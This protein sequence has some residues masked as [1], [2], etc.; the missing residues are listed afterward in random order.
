MDLIIGLAAA[1]LLFLPVLI[2]LI[3]RN[4]MSKKITLLSRTI[5][6]L[7]SGQKVVPLKETQIKLKKERK[8]SRR[9]RRQLR[10]K[11]RSIKR[12]SKPQLN[13]IEKFIGSNILNILGIGAILFGAALFI[14]FS[15]IDAKLS[16]SSRIAISYLGGLTLIVLGFLFRKKTPFFSAVLSGGG[17]AL[18]YFTISLSYLLYEL[19]DWEMASI[20]I[21]ICTLFSIALALG[22]NQAPLAVIA[23][24]GAYI[25]YFLVKPSPQ[26]Y[27]IPQIYILFLTTAVMVLSIIKRWQLLYLTAYVFN[28]LIFGKWIYDNISEDYFD[29]SF[30][31]LLCTALYLLLLASS[32]IF[33]LRKKDPFN[34]IDFLFILTL[35][36]GYFGI[37]LK[38]FDGIENGIY[39]GLF[40]AALALFN[41]VIVL[42]IYKQKNV[43]KNFIY[44]IIGLVITYISLIAPI[45]LDG[46]SITLFWG[47]E[48]VLLVWLQSKVDFKL[49]KNASLGIAGNMLVSLV[50]DW[51][52]IYYDT[53]LEIDLFLNKGFLA[54]VFALFS[55]AIYS[56]LFGK[57]NPKERIVRIPTAIWHLAALVTTFT[58]AY[59]GGMLEINHF[60]SINLENKSLNTIILATYSAFFIYAFQLFTDLT[61]NKKLGNFA[62]I[63]ATIAIII[64]LFEVELSSIKL[65]NSYLTEKISLYYFLIH[66]GG[67]I[68]S[69]LI[70]SR[71]Y[72][73]IHH[74]Y[75]IWSSIH[76]LSYWFLGIALIAL[77]SLEAEH[78]YILINYNPINE[79]SFYNNKAFHYIYPLVWTILASIMIVIGINYK[80]KDLRTFG[81]V[82]TLITIV[83]FAILDYMTLNNIEKASVL[84]GIGI[85]LLCA[86]YFYQKN[87]STLEQNS[88]E[89]RASL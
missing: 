70:I 6:D 30:S 24:C 38:I 46:N 45:Q 5:I 62:L 49:I 23:I 83:K 80:D 57:L 53:S 17:F 14:K 66:Y 35:N 44:L 11:A 2:L 82:V 72:K 47:C 43:D 42:L 85:S 39:N 27:Y 12:A 32:S 29:Q 76:K 50:L 3:V 54:T 31:F 48:A 87:K 73:F 89:S 26:F 18:F 79:I 21:A 13:R 4:Q 25:S 20:L 60:V 36:A 69:I 58:I 41:L 16:D 84:F 10:Y 88:D 22:Y 52:S 71:Y 8:N 67:A 19:M 68:V 81:L 1:T 34:G 77:L 78:I 55:L 37:G 63:L 86:S 51:K 65:R 59:I 75:T 74:T 7:T 28:A 64:Q 40:T 15:V 33:N 9:F 61:H 56:Y